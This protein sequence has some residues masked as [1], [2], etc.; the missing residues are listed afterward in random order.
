MCVEP[1]LAGNRSKKILYSI[2][3]YFLILCLIYFINEIDS[4]TLKV[5]NIMTNFYF[6]LARYS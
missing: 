2:S 4:L 6:N 1:H 3:N 5:I